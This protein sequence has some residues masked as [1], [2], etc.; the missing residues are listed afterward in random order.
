MFVSAIYNGAEIPEN[1][2]RRFPVSPRRREQQK[3]LAT[4]MRVAVVGVKDDVI[5]A[6]L[7]TTGEEVSV[8]CR[9]TQRYLLK[10]VSEGNQ[11]NLVLPRRSRQR[12]DALEAEHIILHPD[13]LV[14]VTTIA[15]CFEDYATDAR[16][17]YFNKIKPSQNTIKDNNY[18]LSKVLEVE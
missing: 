8:I 3:L 12:D 15:S 14:N 18:E 10:L 16:I 17:F 6:T 2:M 11:M 5:V 7:E 4:K 13:L 9:E 1:L